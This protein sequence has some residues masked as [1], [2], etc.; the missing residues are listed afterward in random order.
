MIAYFDP[1]YVQAKASTL[2]RGKTNIC[3]SDYILCQV[4]NRNRARGPEYI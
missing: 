3:I 1:Q 2:K 4:D